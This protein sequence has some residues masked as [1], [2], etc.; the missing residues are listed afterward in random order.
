MHNTGSPGKNDSAKNVIMSVHAETSALFKIP[1]SQRSK[2]YLIVVRITD[3]SVS[4]LGYKLSM[5]KPCNCCTK[6]L[7]KFK[8]KVFYSQ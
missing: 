1:V 7:N 2:V 5:S 6:L 8:V 3:D 4:S